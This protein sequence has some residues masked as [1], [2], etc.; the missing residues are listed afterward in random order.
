MNLKKKKKDKKLKEKSLKKQKYDALQKGKDE[1]IAKM[2]SIREPDRDDEHHQN[3][4][5]KID[6]FYGLKRRKDAD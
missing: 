4:E 5:D 3:N 6:D 2:Q 1:R